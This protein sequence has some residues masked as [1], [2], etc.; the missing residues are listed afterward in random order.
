MFTVTKGLTTI[1]ALAI[2]GA[3][4]TILRYALSEWL[5]QIYKS[6]PA[7]TLI[8]NIL[9][10]F[11]IGILLVLL[12]Y[13]WQVS[14]TQ[15]IMWITGFLGGFTT[16]STFALEGWQLLNAHPT[17]GLLYIVGS[18]TGGLIAVSIG[19]VLGKTLL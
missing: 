8:V 3:L 18:I 2:G 10:S 4:G 17:K 6:F 16:F 12:M 19:I 13:K 1:V 15:K 5:K 7:G 14:G 9:G 11:M